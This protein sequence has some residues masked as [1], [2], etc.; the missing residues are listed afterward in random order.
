MIATSIFRSNHHL[1]SCRCNDGVWRTTMI[2]GT[3]LREQRS[4]M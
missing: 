3:I 2:G 1:T 4:Q